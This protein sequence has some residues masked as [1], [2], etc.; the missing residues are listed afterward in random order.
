MTTPNQDITADNCPAGILLKSLSGKWKP[1][2]FKLGVQGSLRFNTLLRQLEGIN[3]QSLAS[4]LREMEEAG[5]LT[6]QMIR[7]KPLHIEYYL[8]EYGQKMIP[9]FET[10]ENMLV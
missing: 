1:Q 7:L 4:A 8:S 10:I 3:K 6:K 5:F 9:V 2:I